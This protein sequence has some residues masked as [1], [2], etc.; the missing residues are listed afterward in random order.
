MNSFILILSKGRNYYEPVN[1]SIC[2]ICC[3][4][5]S[6]RYTG[7]QDKS[8]AGLHVDFFGNSVYRIL[9]G[10]AVFCRRRFAVYESGL[11][12]ARINA[13]EHGQHHYPGAV[14]K[15]VEDSLYWI[16]SGSLYLRYRLF[17]WFHFYGQDLCLCWRASGSWRNG[18]VSGYDGAFAE[19]RASDSGHLSACC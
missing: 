19:R 7:S 14:F 2:Y 16:H 5:G 3:D 12:S 8:V 6:Q 13:D 15:G 9:A 10:H 17:C 11:C 4:A 18:S 1:H